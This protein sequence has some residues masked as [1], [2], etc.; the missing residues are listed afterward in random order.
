M[1]EGCVVVH[2]DELITSLFLQVLI[3]F[4]HLESGGGPRPASP[5]AGACRGSRSRRGASRRGRRRRGRRR[6][7]RSVWLG[8]LARNSRVVLVVLRILAESAA[9]E[10]VPDGAF[11]GTV[12]AVNVGLEP[13]VAGG[14]EGGVAGLDGEGVEEEVQED[15]VAFGAAK[16]ELDS[17]LQIRWEVIEKGR[18]KR[19]CEQFRR[20]R[21]QR[22]ERR[23]RYGAC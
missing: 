12:V 15:D 13:G 3:S 20:I 23:R 1:R 6:S 11:V 2:I 22:R 7:S 10:S 5:G 4:A 17:K 19:Q 16:E 18:T 14:G 8:A 9:G 21:A